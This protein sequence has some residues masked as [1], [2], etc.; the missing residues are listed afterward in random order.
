MSFFSFTKL[1]GK[2]GCAWGGWYQ[3]EWG[4]GKEMVKEGEYGAK[5][6]VHVYVKRKMIPVETILGMGGD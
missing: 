1:E 5:Y 4:E 3:W 6:C 2:T